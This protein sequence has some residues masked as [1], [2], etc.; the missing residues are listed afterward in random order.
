MDVHLQQL[1]EL[2]NGKTRVFYDPK[3]GEGIDRIGPWNY[4]GIDA[5]RHNDVTALTN[6]R[7]AGPLEGP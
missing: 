7:K 5:V 3:H 6:D 4:Q 2:L 1:T